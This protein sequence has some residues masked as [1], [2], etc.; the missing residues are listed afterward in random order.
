MP[1]TYPRAIMRTR[2]KRRGVPHGLP[3]ARSGETIPA[4]LQVTVV[5]PLK[6][7][8]TEPIVIMITLYLGLNFGVLFQFFISVPAVLSEV[9]SFTMQE[10]ALAFN[11]AIVG[12]LAAAVTS[13][14]LDR[15]SYPRALKKA[16]D[17]HVD[18]EYRLLPALIGS[19]GIVASLYWIGW[20]AKPTIMWPSPVLGTALYVWGNMS[21]LVSPH[22]LNSHLYHLL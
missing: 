14:L 3:P 8:V 17:D 19:L 5:Q 4:M 2:A 7:L 12:A 1:E 16:M 20:T 6:M 9:Y 21:V 22:S 18:I 11:A 10:I 15:I 13:I